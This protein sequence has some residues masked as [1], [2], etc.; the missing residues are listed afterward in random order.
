MGICPN[1][2]R[3]VPSLQSRS[4]S[5]GALEL[6]QL[7]SA[8]PSLLLVALT[9]SPDLV[10]DCKL[11]NLLLH[12]IP[13]LKR[14]SDGSWSDKVLVTNTKP[15]FPC[16]GAVKPRASRVKHMQLITKFHHTNP[17][18]AYQ[19]ARDIF[20]LW[21][22]S[23]PLTVR[24]EKEKWYSTPFKKEYPVSRTMTLG[25]SGLGPGSQSAILIPHTHTPKTCNN[26]PWLPSSWVSMCS[27]I[28]WWLQ[29]PTLGP[30][31]SPRPHPLWISPCDHFSI[32]AKGMST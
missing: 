30:P 1:L 26:G 19:R 7:H 28:G 9:Q 25:G 21:F 27:H 14:T 31:T 20:L 13:N 32:R 15:P 11:V 16:G 5:T 10:R 23:T 17:N 3:L 18:S 29:K 2:P 12:S 8:L 4:S 6:Q 24:A 22:L